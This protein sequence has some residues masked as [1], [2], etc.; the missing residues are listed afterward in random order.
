MFRITLYVFQSNE[1]QQLKHW[2]YD[3]AVVGIT[4]GRL[5][6][7]NLEGRRVNH[8]GLYMYYHIKSTQPPIP[9]AGIEASAFACVRWQVTPCNPIWHMMFHGFR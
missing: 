1:Q 5:S 6:D 4:H 7:H 2:I 9:L 3:Q 8:I